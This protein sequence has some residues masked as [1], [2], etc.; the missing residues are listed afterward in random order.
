MTVVQKNKKKFSTPAVLLL[1]VGLLINSQLLFAGENRCSVA[2]DPVEIRILPAKS[3]AVFGKKNPVK[4]RAS[5]KNNLETDQ[6]GTLFYT[7]RNNQHE[8]HSTGSYAVKVAAKKTFESAFVIPFNENGAFTIRFDLTLNDFTGDL[9]SEFTYKDPKSLKQ[10]KP[11]NPYELNNTA[12]NFEKIASAEDIPEDPD[13]HTEGEL[14]ASD[15]EGEI[16]TVIKP[17]NRDGVF[18]DPDNI[19]YQVHLTNKYKVKQEGT[20]TYILKADNGETLETRVVA[21]K[22][23]RKGSKQFKI[24]I[25]PVS[26]PGVYGITVALNLT[27]YD[28]TTKYA[29]GYKVS[30]I[31]S[32]Y[33]KPPDFE[34]FW[35]TAK[36]ELAAIDPKYNIILDQTRTTRFHKVY[37][38]EMIS[39][40]E[41]KIFGWLTIPRLPGKYPVIVGLQGYRV[42]LEPLL[43]EN[44]IGFN[45]NTRGIEKNWKPFNP[46]NEQPLLINIADKDRYMYRGMYM[47]CVRAIDFIYSHEEMGFDLS[48]VLVF[49]G[50]QGATLSLVTAALT[51]NRIN[52]LIV[53]NPIFCDFHESYKLL[54]NPLYDN[55]PIKHVVDYTK[56][57]PS[58]TI[59][60]LL[61]N[62]SYF[63]VQNFMPMINC[64]VLYAVSLLDPLA[65]AAT[66][67]AAF[68]KLNP[69]TIG[70]SEMYV[71]PHLG[72][73]ITMEHRH[74]QMIWMSE[75]LLRKRQNI[76][77]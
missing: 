13:Q 26:S 15:D 22:L 70:K 68:N 31:A 52:S 51:G 19:G 62:L 47:D 7:I 24:K 20:L 77:K 14:E 23:A 41:V 38:V 67:I 71:A 48:R 69:A 60:Q 49:G 56:D 65:P 39:L 74:Y 55:F 21:I 6:E 34:A 66:V 43:Y 3:K 30:G 76:G 35:E 10:D 59:E 75:K 4:Y 33:H 12:A 40:N 73:E 57:N 63:E 61:D 1:L 58:V 50:S 45:L 72:H 25:P 16:I 18:W 9:T 2:G 44:N 46:E 27:T 53:D 64:S 54:G 5:F 32:P 17:I 42:E 29:F 37:K 28:D 36:A 8:I 11:G